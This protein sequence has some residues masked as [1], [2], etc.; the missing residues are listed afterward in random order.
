M[1]GVLIADGEGLCGDATTTDVAAVVYEE[2]S[3]AVDRCVEG[4]LDLDAPAGAYKVD[5]LV[6]D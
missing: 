1:Q 3:G 5:V 6:G 4:N 2:T